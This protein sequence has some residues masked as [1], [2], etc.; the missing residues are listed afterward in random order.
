MDQLFTGVGS[1]VGDAVVEDRVLV[2]C[3]RDPAE[4]GYQIR[5][6]ASVDPRFE[7]PSQPVPSLDLGLVLGGHLGHGGLVLGG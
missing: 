3:Q 4:P 7:A 5:L 6:A 1:R 2:A